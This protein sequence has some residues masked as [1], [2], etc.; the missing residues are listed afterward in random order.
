MGIPSYSP[1]FDPIDT[2]LGCTK[3]KI[4]PKCLRDIEEM[5]REMM[6][7]WD[8]MSQKLIHHFTNS[9][10]RRIQQYIEM[11]GGLT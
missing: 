10:T 5:M 4:N 6:S 9:M 3:D 8:S 2:I 11:E 1:D 7:Y